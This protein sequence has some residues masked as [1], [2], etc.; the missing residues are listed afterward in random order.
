MWVS[1]ELVHIQ[2]IYMN[3]SNKIKQMGNRHREA[4]VESNISV[5][6]PK[7]SGE[8]GTCPDSAPDKVRI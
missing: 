3:P 7:D 8:M 6:F 1:S 4:G 5:S 2:D